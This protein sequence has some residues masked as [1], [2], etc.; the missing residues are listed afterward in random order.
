M[1]LARLRASVMVLR[2]LLP[3]RVCMGMLLLL[4]LMQLLSLTQA[5]DVCIKWPTLSGPSEIEL[6]LCGNGILDAG[7]VCDDG[8]RIG[9]DGCNAWCSGFDRM[10]RVCTMAG[11]NLFYA[12]GDQKQC[13]GAA[14]AAGGRNFGPAQAFFCN[15]NAIAA[16][17]DGTFLIVAD[18]GLLIRMDLFTDAFSSSLSILPATAIQPLARVCS[19]A[20]ISNSVVIAHECH[21]QSILLFVNGGTQ[22][23]KPFS[24]PLLRPVTQRAST[25]S[26]LDG[27]DLLLYAGVPQHEEE[28]GCVHVYAFNATS[29]RGTLLA[30]IE[31][32]VYNVI[33]KGLIYPSFSIA[34]MVPYQITKEGCPFQMHATT[35]YV[36]YMERADMQVLKAYIAV[37]GGLDIQYTISTD[38]AVN[39]LGAPLIT[40]GQKSGNK[41]TLMG[42]CFTMTPQASSAY[43]KRPPPMVALGNACGPLPFQSSAAPCSTPLNNPFIT[44]VATSSYLLPQGLS[45]RLQHQSLLSIFN[46]S[47]LPLYRQILDNTHNGTVPIDFVELPGTLDVVYITQTTIGLISTKGIVHMDIYNPGYCR[48]TQAI[49][50][51]NGFYG[52]VAGGVCRSC[53]SSEPD[54]SVSAQI[55]CT[56]LQQQQQQQQQGAKAGGS[57]FQSAPYTHV[58]LIATKDVTQ[59]LL[60]T[61]AS[62]YMVM[63]GVD[64][65]TTTTTT[66]GEGEGGGTM[67]HEPYNMQADYAEAQIQP[68]DKQLIT[69]LV[70]A[71]SHRDMRNY[72]AQVSDE[73]LISWTSQQ[74]ALID[75]LNT[76]AAYDRPADEVAQI[77]E[78]KCGMP[79][80]MVAALLQAS[81]CRAKLNKDFHRQWLPCMVPIALG[82][83]V[84]KNTSRRRALLQQGAAAPPP[85]PSS[86]VLI[87][88]SPCTFMSTTSVTYATADRFADKF[89]P[90]SRS[91]SPGPSG[92]GSGV[93]S[94]G[95][96]WI[97][98]G[99]IAGGLLV[100]GLLVIVIYIYCIASPSPSAARAGANG[101]Y[102]SA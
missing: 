31:C 26:Y 72:S 93:D 58:G 89:G 62:F 11:Q 63:K 91:R 2:L 51:P 25:R 14:A 42:N 46:A 76:V 65:C 61:L 84:E 8:N 43:V 5:Q 7:E 6:P 82:V 33:E 59:S 20:I 56:G 17:P 44:E 35:C 22:V 37:D 92:S 34:G 30:S 53:T 102:K 16:S 50:C 64:N 79:T 29:S 85:P 47:N 52:S 77:L 87:E 4:L 27:G 90:D 38:D 68:T 10:T 28:N 13:L 32:V 1:R 100:S 19:I 101:D 18:G 40:Q 48:A 73:Y 97:I 15:L 70:K 57:S 71:A 75:S 96:T 49:L 67:A 78:Q 41:Y 3:K 12:S 88:H 9:G 24:M 39:V 60:D 95:A 99:G 86:A 54:S 45:S 36:V 98:L 55:Q 21:E 69:E 83:T 66:Q 94:A 81:V 23:S 74:T 80:Q